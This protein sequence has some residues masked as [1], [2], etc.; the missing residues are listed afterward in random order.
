MA[1][2]RHGTGP[3]LGSV[4]EEEGLLVVQLDSLRVEIYGSRPIT[5]GEG[6]VALVLEVD[7]FLRHG[8]GFDEGSVLGPSS[9]GEIREV[10]GIGFGFG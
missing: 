10:G 3:Y 4:R 5:V 7:G 8:G 2:G 1:R 6:L 9:H